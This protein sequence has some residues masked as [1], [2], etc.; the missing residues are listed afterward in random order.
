[1]STSCPA[2]VA[3]SRESPLL[4]WLD[5]APLRVAALLS[6]FTL[7]AGYEALRLSALADNDIWWHLR[8]GL[9]ILQDH[10]IPRTGL[11][12]QWSSLPWIDVSWGFDLLTALAYWRF[13]LAALPLWLMFGQLAIAAALFLLARTASQKFWPAV[14]LAAIG[15][16]CI[17]P[18]QPR[19]ALCSIF[20]LAVELAILLTSRRTRDAQR[21]LWLPPMFLLWANL[22]RQ[23]AYGLLALALFCVA[24]LI[25][26]LGRN[27][28]LPWLNS[29]LATIDGAKLALAAVA[30]L[31]ATFFT[32]YTWRLHALIW[33]TATSSAADRYFRPLHAM[34]FRQPQDYALM[35]LVMTAFFALG[36]RRS[37]DLFLIPLLIIA[38]VISFRLQRDN[39]LVVVVSIAITA[40]ALLS[41]EED[42]ASEAS[43]PYG[44]DT[45]LAAALSLI[46]A[47]AV[48]LRIGATKSLHPKLSASFPVA[49]AEYIR[50]RQLPQ[51]LFNAYEWG[52]FLTWYLPEY[53]VYIDGRADLYGD[54]V[55]IPYFKLMQAEIPL[56]AHPGFASAQ[57]FLLQASSPLGQ[58][59]ASLPGFQIAYRDNL[60]VVIVRER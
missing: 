59:L 41:R 17:V 4:R 57:T 40:N 3:T 16:C 48:G 51:P 2:T 46:L 21:L 44:R 32:P 9:W 33:Q 56:Q 22:D 24:A 28:N 43:P 26:R 50:Q 10:A 60:A 31:L 54:D 38:A 20:F 39:W 23:F 37:R 36:R 49:A 53:P 18:L 30:S 25:E 15:Q 34:R 13:G 1:M 14:I 42:G 55:N 5:R 19:P 52:G 58:A 47:A 8:T 27:S 11:F 7:P 45:I 35:L 12:S 29:G 6:A